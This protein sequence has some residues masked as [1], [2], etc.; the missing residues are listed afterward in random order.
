MAFK[1][2]VLTKLQGVIEMRQNQTEGRFTT[3]ESDLS[4]AKALSLEYDE[5]INRFHREAHLELSQNKKKID[6]QEKETFQKEEKIRL[7]AFEAKSQALLKEMEAHKK[8]VSKPIDEL[9]QN[10]VQKLT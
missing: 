1:T 2:L 5:K 8:T 3:A 7:E 10:L 6:E 9:S 4:Q